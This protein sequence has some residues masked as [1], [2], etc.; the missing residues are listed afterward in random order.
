MNKVYM[1]FQEGNQKGTLVNTPEK[2]RQL[3]TVIHIIF[4]KE[5]TEG[6]Q[7]VV[8]FLIK[9][10]DVFGRETIMQYAI[11]ERNMDGVVGAFIGC[12]IRWGTMEPDQMAVIKMYLNEQSEQILKQI[13]VW[14]NSTD[15]KKIDKDIFMKFIDLYILRGGRI[16]YE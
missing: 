9:G 6:K 16:S 15:N 12:R 7:I 8:D 3:E 10:V 5:A 2:A 14:N 13:D 4:M 11:T 1:H